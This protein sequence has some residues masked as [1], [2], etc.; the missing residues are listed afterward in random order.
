MIGAIIWD[1][2]GSRFEFNNYR[3]THFKLIDK[4]CMF[5]DYTVFTVALIDWSLSKNDSKEEII[6]FLDDLKKIK[7]KVKL[8]IMPK[9]KPLGLRQLN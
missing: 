3:D 6:N 9:F 5:R 1:V 2:I 8:N 4:G 7:R